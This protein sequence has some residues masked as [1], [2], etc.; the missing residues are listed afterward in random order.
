MII[1]INLT[2]TE[3]GLAE[4]KAELAE[5][6]GLEAAKKAFIEDLLSD[7]DTPDEIAAIEIQVDAPELEGG[8]A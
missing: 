7:R 6:G 4:A 8:A 1:T 3:K 2:L 5:A